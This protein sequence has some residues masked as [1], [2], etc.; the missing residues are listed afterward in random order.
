MRQPM[1]LLVWPC[2]RLWGHQFTSATKTCIIMRPSE[3]P[4]LKLKHHVDFPLYQ[5]V[6][7]MP[8]VT[9]YGHRVNL[10]TNPESRVF[11]SL[12]SRMDK[13]CKPGISEKE[14]D[15]AATTANHQLATTGTIA[16]V[17]VTHFGGTSQLI[18][19]RCQKETAAL[20]AIHSTIYVTEGAGG[21]GDNH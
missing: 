1:R 15:N 10:R 18:K 13:L 16:Q 17:V 19:D 4:L 3:N 9:R 12:A 21:V 7:V 2:S 20:A 5:H 6:L 8:G 11:K 14:K